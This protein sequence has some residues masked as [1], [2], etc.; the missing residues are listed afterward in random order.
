MAGIKY[1]KQIRDA[2]RDIRSNTGVF[3][4]DIQSDSTTAT[5]AE[6]A[7][8]I[9]TGAARQNVDVFSDV[10]GATDV[11]LEVSLDDS[12]WREIQRFEEEGA[13][14]RFIQ[15]DTV[16]KYVRVYADTTVTEI[17]VVSKGV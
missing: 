5:G 1:A 13:N 8:K 2:L 14:T 11:V 15:L 16:Y 4:S 3:A 10:D 6:N 7:A 17:E 9:D 12:T